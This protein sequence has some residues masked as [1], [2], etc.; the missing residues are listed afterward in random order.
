[1]E[2]ERAGDQTFL[3]GVRMTMKSFADLGLEV[4]VTE[5]D[6]RIDAP[7][8]DDDLSQQA[9]LYGEIFDIC[10]AAPNCTAFMMW[11]FTDKYSWIPKS[12]P[13]DGDALILDDR[14]A[15]KPAYN[16]LHD[17]LAALP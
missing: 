1:V 3:D 5:L 16:T 15:F 8:T 10:H 4:T 12:F 9:Q 11:G 2:V 17:R 14:F 6:V 13:G 7:T